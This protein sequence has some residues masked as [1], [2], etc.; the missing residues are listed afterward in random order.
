[1]ILTNLLRHIS[2]KHVRFQKMQTLLSVLGICIGVSA[3]V[4]MGIVNDNIL[5]S[6]RD[7]INYSMGKAALQVTGQATGFPEDVVDRVQKA[8]GVEYAVPAIEATGTIYGAQ[9]R[10]ILVLGVDLL[11]DQMIRQYKLAD[12]S[13]DIPDPLLF[14]AKADSILLTKELADREGIKIGQR[15]KVQ[16]VE[17]IHSFK[18]R[19][20]LSPEGPAKAMAGN[21]AVM[22]IF[23]AQKAFCRQGKIDRI[24]ISL[25]KGSDLE[26]VKKAVQAALP[27]GYSVESPAGRT[28]QIE[29]MI[30]R[31]QKSLDLARFIIIFVGMYII[32]NSVSITVVHRKK[33]IGIL[34]ALGATKARIVSFFVA[35]ALVNG[36][37]GSALGV[38]L[39]IAQAKASIGAI[40]QL[41]SEVYLNTSIGEINI[42]WPH[43][44]IG[45][46]SG[47]SASLIAALFPAF[48]SSR[49]SP[50]AAIRSTP[51]TEEA[52]FT[53]RRMTI[54]ASA[55]VSLAA[56]L[57]ILY[58]T[59]PSS[60]YFHSMMNVFLSCLFLLL[61]ISLAMP[62]ALGLFLRIFHKTLSQSLG[63]PGRLAGL[64]LRKNL[65][66]NSVAAAAIFFGISMYVNSAGFQ[67][68]VETSMNRY[69]DALLRADIIVTAGRPLATAGSQNTLM[70][71][72]VMEDVKKIPG[73][74][75]ADPYRKIYVDYGENRILL[76][77]VDI[78]QKL[79]YTNFFIF[80]GSREDIIKHLP[81]RDAIVIN[82]GLAAK[83]RVKRGGSLRLPTPNGP[84]AFAVIAVIEDY[85]FDGGTL[86]M[87][88]R[89]FQ[90]HWDDRLVDMI[91]VRTTS[92]DAVPGVVRTIE[93]KFGSERKLFVLPLREWKGRL[94]KL[95]GD[96]FVFNHA[97]TFLTLTIACFGI[98]VTLF[99]SVLERT[100]EIGVLRSIGML[101]TQVFRIVLIE[102]MILGLVGGLLGC[103]GGIVMG[104]ASLKGFFSADYGP[105]MAYALP[106]SSIFW[107]LLLS[108]TIAALSSIYPAWR[109]AKTNIVEALAYE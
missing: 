55:F 36:A 16:T 43:L 88:I 65:V 4:S 107:A 7:T 47:V 79:A 28:K 34:R 89:T 93:K 68:S 2:L 14:L 75:S 26:E 52:F 21:M 85:T 66:R 104:W 17:G 40:S 37:I 94:M 80:Q 77:A 76:M 1:M 72:Q 63:A 42:T 73:V 92:K 90:R 24:D 82:E 105:S 27:T 3:I 29:N 102:S 74:L 41:F 46:A 13:A 23:A 30:S 101:R 86:Y 9:E 71:V 81:G 6:F 39:G 64:N 60:P 50:V 57:L 106:Y 98:I 12:E 61:G 53:N 99:A 33:E 8:A 103:L 19:G 22:D 38:W 62:Y 31:L 70:P 5:A 56:A 11:Q 51:Y 20:L 48:A 100:R 97:I 58:R 109:A 78:Q 83:Y 54:L 25:L 87:D 96:S 35:E 59:L 49:I 32:Y 91:S 95:V 67:H 45:F 18:V 84:V 15:I 69:L 10:A 108:V 44:V